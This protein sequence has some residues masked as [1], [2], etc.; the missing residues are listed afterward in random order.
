MQAGTQQ[1]CQAIVR[2]TVPLL[3]AKFDADT[4]KSVSVG[5]AVSGMN[6]ADEP[7]LIKF[8]V[9]LTRGI[10]CWK[11]AAIFSN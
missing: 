11:V 6:N 10:V 8:P 3:V 5:L 7:P 4:T 9:S 2:L 1:T